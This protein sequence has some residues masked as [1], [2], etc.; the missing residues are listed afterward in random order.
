MAAAQAGAP[1]IIINRDE[2]DHDSLPLV[3]LRL[4]GNVEELFPPAVDDALNGD[5]S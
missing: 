4:T 3:T 1:Y 2:T 5:S